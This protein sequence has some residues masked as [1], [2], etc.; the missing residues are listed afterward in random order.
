MSPSTATQSVSEDLFFFKDFSGDYKRGIDL[1]LISLLRL[2]HFAWFKILRFARPSCILPSLFLICN[3][4][5]LS[6][7]EI[8]Q[9]SRSG[10][11]LGHQRVFILSINLPA[12]CCYVTNHSKF[13]A[14]IQRHLLWSWI[15]HLG[16]AW[17]GMLVHVISAWA[18][19]RWWTGTI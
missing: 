1:M 14:V 3:V 15:F 11:N 2:V 13:T 12:I 17:Q 5:L 18:A 6:P 19:Q 16:R 8:R 10:R 9:N 4:E 7:I